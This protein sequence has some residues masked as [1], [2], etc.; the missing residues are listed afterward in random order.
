MLQTSE[1][2]IPWALAASAHYWNDMKSLHRFRLQESPQWWWGE[3]YDTEH[4]GHLLLFHR[5]SSALEINQRHSQSLKHR[6]QSSRAHLCISTVLP[7]SAWQPFVQSNS[8]RTLPILAT[9]PWEPIT[10]FPSTTSISNSQESLEGWRNFWVVLRNKL[11]LC[12]LARVSQNL[13]PTTL[14]FPLF[15]AGISDI[16]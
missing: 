4:L 2:S 14:Y 8:I 6:N 13:S 9:M 5:R 15:N 3:A 11:G 12:G 10:C 1:Y 16:P 7:H